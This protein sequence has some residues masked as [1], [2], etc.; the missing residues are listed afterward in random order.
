MLILTVHI[1]TSTNTNNVLD[2][3]Y[4]ALSD[5]QNTQKDWLSLE[6]TAMQ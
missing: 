5:L 2:K 4:G 1:P 6:I 3:L